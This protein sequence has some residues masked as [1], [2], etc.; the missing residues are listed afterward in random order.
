VTLTSVASDVHQP[1]DVLPD[2]PTQITL[3]NQLTLNHLAKPV[4]F[5]FGKRTDLTPRV[6]TACLQGLARQGATNPVDIR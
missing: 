1:L 4:D 6:N 3:N 5:L 2:H